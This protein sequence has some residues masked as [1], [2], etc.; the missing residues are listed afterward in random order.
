MAKAKNVVAEIEP[1][2]KPLAG[3][4]IVVT[5]ARAQAGSLA[6]RLEKLGS[7]VIEFPTIEIQ[8]PETYAPLD[9]AIGNIQTYDWLIFTS[10]NG[11]EQFFNRVAVLNRSA[12]ELKR[13]LLAAIGP[14]TANRLAA[15]GLQS[16]FVPKQY[17][18]E[19]LLEM[20]TEEKIQ[21]KRVLIPRAA[22]AR[23]I[24]PQTLRERGAH[25]DVVEVYR[26]VTPMKD[27]SGFLRSLARREIDM[28]T[29]TSS[30]TVTNFLRLLN[31]ESLAG[32][33]GGAAIACIG[34]ITQ[35]TVEQLGGSADVVASE[36]TIPGLVS[37]ITEY[38]EKKPQRNQG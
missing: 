26:T 33:L 37:A 6:D 25:V 15:L 20:L 35:N 21:G 29:F 24:L 31:K 30:S 9:S 27:V 18:A 16:H 34:P 14:E 2:S 22:K 5:R 28:V 19:G 32:E 7:T 23:E 12:L 3:K 17:Q 38:F 13:I 8:P 4:R 10:V 11:V 1:Q 36:F